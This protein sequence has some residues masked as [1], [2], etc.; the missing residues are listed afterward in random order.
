MRS[1]LARYIDNPPGGGRPVCLTDARFRRARIARAGS[2]I[3]A[4]AV[5][6][7]RFFVTVASKGFSLH[8]SHLKPIVS[9]G[10]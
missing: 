9:V 4:K 7:P 5:L 10:I 2:L 3:P 1:G 6:P 8:T